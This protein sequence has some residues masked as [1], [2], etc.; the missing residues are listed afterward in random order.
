[1]LTNSNA[2]KKS[3]LEIQ[4]AVRWG[5]KTNL[6]SVPTDCDNRDERRG[7]SGDAELTAEECLLNFEPSA[8][9]TKWMVTR[10]YV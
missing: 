8:L 10:M 6:M 9:Y 1:M 3:K 5:Q 4:H 7:W 2:E